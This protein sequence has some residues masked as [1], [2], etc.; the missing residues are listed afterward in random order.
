M[1][2][3]IA[4]A[5]PAITGMSE[6]SSSA[7]IV[8][9]SHGHES[10]PDAAK[11][12]ALRPVA[13]A[14]GFVT[15][16]IDYRDLR[17]DPVGRRN[18]LVRRLGSVDATVVLVG[19]S[20]GGWVS[21]AAAERCPVAGLWLMAPALF[22]EDRVPGGMVPDTYR[23]KADHV[24]LVHGWRDEVI[25]WGNSLRFASASRAE[26]HL[27]DADH[28]LESAIPRLQGLMADFLAGA[29][30]HRDPE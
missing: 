27:L 6:A 19:S 21:M 26:L 9:F 12:R 24:A 11:I 18:R 5:S 23:P 25:P 20:L 13:E 14:A 10:S 3:R 1:E 7:N 2:D 30:V 15:E 16:A 22:L 29:T 8:I 28:R 4:A 17:D